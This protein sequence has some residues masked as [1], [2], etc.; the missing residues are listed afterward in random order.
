METERLPFLW[1]P[2]L[3]SCSSSFSSIGSCGSLQ[4]SLKHPTAIAC[5]ST[6]RRSNIFLNAAVRTLL[7]ELAGEGFDISTSKRVD[8]I[9]A[10][11]DELGG[12]ERAAGRFQNPRTLGVARSELLCV[13]HGVSLRLVL[14]ELR[15]D[16][17]TR[18]QPPCEELAKCLQL[19]RVAFTANEHD[20][21]RGYV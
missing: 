11:V 2:F 7:R 6:G 17:L 8:S 19:R 4:N 13:L 10:R 14:L 21:A 9:I 1:R 20:T 12:I 3:L 5:V 15:I 16:L 18:L